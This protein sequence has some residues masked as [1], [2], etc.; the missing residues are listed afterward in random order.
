MIEFYDPLVDVIQATVNLYGDVDAIIQYHPELKRSWKPSLRFGRRVCGETYF[1]DD[2]A[3][4]VISLNPDIPLKHIIEI[5]A[6]ELA[7]VVVGYD[8]DHDSDWKYAF[9]RI[10]DEYLKISEER[11]KN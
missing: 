2:E 5:L 4:P 1:P 6:H 10:H 3:T 11:M 9:D 8:R 7:H